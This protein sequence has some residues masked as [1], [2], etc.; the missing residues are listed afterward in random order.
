MMSKIIEDNY[1]YNKGITP[2]EN[3]ICSL[4]LECSC[5]GF[6]HIDDD[7]IRH[8]ALEISNVIKKSR[9]DDDN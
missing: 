5:C 8:Y 2:L 7:R 3:I 9:G 4:L 6:Y 1:N